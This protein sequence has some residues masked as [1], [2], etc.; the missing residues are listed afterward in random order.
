MCLFKDVS[1]SGVVCDELEW[2]GK[3]GGAEMLVLVVGSA[4]G[5]EGKLACK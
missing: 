2:N 5:K 3:E 1:Y 4:R